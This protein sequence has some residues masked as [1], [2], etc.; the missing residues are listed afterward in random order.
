MED[1]EAAAPAHVG[2]AF[3]DES[4]VHTSTTDANERIQIALG[5]KPGRFLYEVPFQSESD[6]GGATIS[7]RNA[8][9]VSC[10]PAAVWMLLSATEN[11]PS[12]STFADFIAQA[13]NGR[14]P[15]WGWTHQG[16]QE[17]AQGYDVTLEVNDY[18][19]Q[20]RFTKGEA[21]EQLV[22]DL[23]RSPVAVSIRQIDPITKV[24]ETRNTHMIVLRGA[25]SN[26]QG[27]VTFF[28]NDPIAKS[29][30]TPRNPAG[31]QARDRRVGVTSLS[32]GFVQD[33]FL[34]RWLALAE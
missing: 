27:D 18:G 1:G 12:G 10:S 3:L 7:G 22:Q 15:Q 25:E 17:T 21:W 19:D 34:G 13:A 29:P 6:V 16:F 30:T 8:S 4:T 9:I 26:G 28:V 24:P 14:H 23:A 31:P 32:G 33:S 11:I 20:E 2:T 5:K